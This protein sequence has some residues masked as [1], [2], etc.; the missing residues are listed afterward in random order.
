M[1]QEHREGIAE[2]YFLRR[3]IA[4]RRWQGRGLEGLATHERLLASWEDRANGLEVELANSIPELAVQQRR[5][6]ANRR[7]VADA[8]PSGSALVEFVRSPDWNPQ[9]AFSQIAPAAPSARYLAF[10]LLA[11]QPEAVRML[12]LG[13]SET[14]DRLVAAYLQTL[15][16]AVGP[17]RA[18]HLPAAGTTL[19]KAVFDRLVPALQGCRRLLLSPDGELGR[20]PFDTLPAEDGAFLI[21]RYAISYLHTGRDLLEAGR[22]YDRM[23]SAPVILGDP[24]FGE[25]GPDS[26]AALKQG[27]NWW[28]RAW[29]AVRGLVPF[30]SR[31]PAPQ[32]TAS[33]NVGCGDS[34]LHFQPLPGTR[35]EAEE[36]AKVF[37]L[38]AYLGSEAAKSRLTACASPRVLHLA[39]HAFCLGQ[40]AVNSVS[41]TPSSPPVPNTAAWKNPLRRAGLAL[42]DA[43]RDDARGRITAWDVTGLDLGLTEVVV[44]PAY[45]VSA[46]APAGL[47]VV[48]LARSFI[49]AG[50]RGVVTTLWPVAD[51]PRRE[52]F[53]DFYRR[54]L[55]GQS[56]AETLR[57][58][59][60]K[61]ASTFSDPAVWGAYVYYGMPA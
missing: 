60:Q 53:A 61:L 8:L 16:S 10:V 14:I 3:Q 36:V 31:Q 6:T 9:K 40:P 49:L 50:A 20:V 17:A 13:P 48:G 57:E 51:K 26:G 12:D 2:L 37:G 39:T 23:C 43:N 55:A 25:A 19:R 28:R 30:R 24:D 47:G 41:P 21:D 29:T 11:G 4:S 22:P 5:R 45:V 18:A 58:A 44:L 1:Y 54:L 27:N 46:E 59:Q 38:R 15:H 32:T 42:A 52:F 33:P 56:S 34:G 7:A 35:R